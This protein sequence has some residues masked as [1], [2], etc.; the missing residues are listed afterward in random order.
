MRQGFW[1]GLGCLVVLLLGSDAQA[2]FKLYNLTSKVG[3]DVVQA[4]DTRRFYVLQADVL[5]LFSPRFRLELGGEMG[6]GADLDDTEI[7]VVGGGAFFKYLWPNEAHNAYAY[8]GAG[9]GLN[10]V[11][12]ERLITNAIEHQM[13]LNL[14]FILIGME[15]NFLKGRAKALFEVRWVIGEEED[16]T[17][18]RTAVGIGVNIGKE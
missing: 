14:H 3:L 5:S 17:A 2:G 18:L 15:K 11:R 7:K 8:M 1:F 9:L 6:S 10:R 4:N 12:R 16:A 13:Q